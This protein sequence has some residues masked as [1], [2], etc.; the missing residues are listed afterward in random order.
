MPG[1]RDT[2]AFENRRSGDG[3]ILALIPAH[4]HLPLGQE[5]RNSHKPPYCRSCLQHFLPSAPSVE[6]KGNHNVVFIEDVRLIPGDKQKAMECVPNS[7]ALWVTLASMRCPEVGLLG[8]PQGACLPIRHGLYCC[9]LEAR[10]LCGVQP[11]PEA[12]PEQ[13]WIPEGGREKRAALHLHTETPSMPTGPRAAHASVCFS[14]LPLLCKYFSRP[15]LLLACRF[16]PTVPLLCP[17]ENF[18]TKAVQ[19]VSHPHSL[20]LG[21]GSGRQGEFQGT[22]AASDRHLG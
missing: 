6:T 9:H 11:V 10:Q 13:K 16:P 17:E 12:L 18:R 22:C 3:T 8:L 7:R 14:T 4:C 21:D 20:A 19:Q 2:E 1:A 5:W 15:P